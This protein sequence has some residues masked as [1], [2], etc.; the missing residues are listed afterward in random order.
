MKQDATCNL[1]GKDFEVT[2][3]IVGDEVIDC[4]PCP[5]CDEK[6]FS[7]RFNIDPNNFK[8]VIGS[9]R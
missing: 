8:G 5:N 4:T 3:I 9:N 2:F 6:S 1:C 7:T